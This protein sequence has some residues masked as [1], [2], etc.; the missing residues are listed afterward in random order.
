[1]PSAGA[2]D[3]RAADIGQLGR[4]GLSAQESAADSP[5][6]QHIE[7]GKPRLW[8]ERAVTLAACFCVTLLMLPV[9]VKRYLLWYTI[10]HSFALLFTVVSVACVFLGN[11]HTKILRFL[12]GKKV[13]IQ[14]VV[15]SL[16]DW[17]RMTLMYVPA[18]V[19]LL[20]FLLADPIGGMPLQ[21]RFAC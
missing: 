20:V 21:V 14:V 15:L 6:P 4:P 5:P 7:N 18:C 10:A 11:T 13:F 16:A 1:M 3:R 9:G 19:N 17:L 2:A 12:T 8:A